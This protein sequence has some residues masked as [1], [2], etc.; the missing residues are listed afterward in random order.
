MHIFW[1]PTSSGEIGYVT[2][3]ME[4]VESDYSN[5]SF[6]FSRILST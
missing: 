5:G 4:M 3:M 6:Y 2:Q 1:Q